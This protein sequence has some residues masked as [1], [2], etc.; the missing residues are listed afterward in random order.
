M[1]WKDRLRPGSFR[2][3]PFKL[4]VV[5]GAGGR[6]LA[7][8]EYPKRDKPHAEDM[9]RKGR[10]YN[11]SAYVLGDDYEA[12]RD[13]LIEALEVEGAATLVHPTFG[14]I[15]VRADDFS[16]EESKS[17][18]GMCRFTLGFVEAGEN[19]FPAA[20]TDTKTSVLSAAKAAKTDLSSAFSKAYTVLNEPGFV[21]GAAALQI[22]DFAALLG[23]LRTGLGSSVEIARTSFASLLSAVL[24]DPESVAAGDVPATVSGL[25]T[26]FRGVA[27]DEAG[28]AG[29]REAGSFAAALQSPPAITPSRLVQANNTE[30]L[31]TL[32]GGMALVERAA[33]ATT[34]TFTSYDDAAALRSRLTSDLNGA[35]VA[36]ADRDDDLSFRALRRVATAVSADLTARGG[37][38][39]RLTTYSRP[40]V[41][42]AVVV[43]YELYGDAARADE[44]VMRNKAV[45]P[46]FLPATGQALNV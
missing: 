46:L 36:A 34:L 21:L 31:S 2:G 42:P 12:A 32:I 28:Q 15:E 8:T 20:T 7:I 19:Q 41:L 16:Y 18:G 35:A 5:G 37:S 38:L 39:A 14:N 30:A 9:G 3:V 13:A 23:G 43:A 33:L 17:E 24:A 29:L 45:H 1:S 26:G 22:S 44:L 6:R 25:L 27:S 4:D 11:F 10:R 40:Q